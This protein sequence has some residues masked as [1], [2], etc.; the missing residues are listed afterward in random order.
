MW[1]LLVLHGHDQLP[2]QVTQETWIFQTQQTHPAG[3]L[4][5]CVLVEYTH[6]LWVSFLL[7]EL[8]LA[9]CIIQWG[10]A[11][12]KFTYEKTEVLFSHVGVVINFFKYVGS[13][14][15]LRAAPL[16][17]VHS[18]HLGSS[19]VL[20][21]VLHHYLGF[22]AELHYSFHKIYVRFLDVFTVNCQ[23]EISLSQFPGSRAILLQ[24]TNELLCRKGCSRVTH[25]NC[26]YQGTSCSITLYDTTSTT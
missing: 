21:C 1:F 7:K 2:W 22:S 17:I 6:P 25:S 18:P 16:E 13:T 9:T 24:Y 26:Y 19:R 23:R 20:R 4:A 10:D 14:F 11:Y 3:L 5:D 12:V 15:R 8:A